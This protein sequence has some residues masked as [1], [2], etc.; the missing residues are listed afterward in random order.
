MNKHEVYEELLFSDSPV[1]IVFAKANGTLRTMKATL[2]KNL[3]PQKNETGP[4]EAKQRKT[5]PEVRP[6]WDTEAE[7]WRSFRWDSVS[8][9]N[10]VQFENVT[11]VP[12]F[13]YYNGNQ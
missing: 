11:E 3:I 10:G 9:V 2:N 5:N 8:T 13:E 6:V 4:K 7:G 12:G 1:E